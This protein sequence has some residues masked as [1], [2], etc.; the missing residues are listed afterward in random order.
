[1]KINNTLTLIISKN[2]AKGFGVSIDPKRD[3]GIRLLRKLVEEDA[4]S[5]DQFQLAVKIM[6][7]CNKAVHG[8]HVSYEQAL[9]IIDS[10]DVR[11]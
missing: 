4:I 1:M 3:S 9:S 5:D 8:E 10:A 7:V 11:R 6:N 2:L